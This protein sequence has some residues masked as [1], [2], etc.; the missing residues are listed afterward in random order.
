MAEL[1]HTLRA[2]SEAT[3]VV[4]HPL[5]PLTPAEIRAAAAIVRRERK[6]GDDARFA[7]IRLHEPPKD[8]VRTFVPG[9]PI[10]RRAWVVVMETARGLLHDG[11]VSLGRET[12]EEWTPRPGL[13]GP[14]LL[15]EYE[16]AAEL[17]R[18]DP[19][20]QAAGRR[21]GV[22]DVD[23]VR[24]DAWM[25]GNFGLPDEEGRRVCASLSYLAEHA[26][27]LPYAR[28][29]E[30]GFAYVDLSTMTLTKVLDPA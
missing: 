20:W 25:V 6:L 1:A 3:D 8:V 10:E 17:I 16:Q 24:I 26:L 13:Q 5:D 2:S 12:V 30:G 4:S 19:R 29:I 9:A 14:L 23:A 21:R 27:D 7:S 15:D 28:P 22:D 11:V 18:A